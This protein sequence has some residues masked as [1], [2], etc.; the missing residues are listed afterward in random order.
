MKQVPDRSFGASGTTSE[1]VTPLD[2]I[3]NRREA[4]VRACPE[5]VEGNLL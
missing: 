5:P 4:A 2:V 3:P 1:F